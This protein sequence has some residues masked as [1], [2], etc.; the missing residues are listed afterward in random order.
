MPDAIHLP[1]LIADE[2]PEISRSETRRLFSSGAIK[3]NGKPLTLS[4]YDRRHLE[5][6]TITVGK[7]RS[8]VVGGEAK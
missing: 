2:F 3:L 7:K 1:S 4:D 5:G 6:K 8:F